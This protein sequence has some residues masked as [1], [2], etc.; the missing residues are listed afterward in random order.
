MGK[1]KRE[2]KK[3]QL[4]HFN[5]SLSIP[6]VEKIIPSAFKPVWKVILNAKYLLF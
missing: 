2:D 3:N 1:R 6:L 4:K 5:F